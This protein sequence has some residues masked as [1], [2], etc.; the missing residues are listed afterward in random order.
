MQALQRLY[1]GLHLRIN[2]AKSAVAPAH[3]RKFLG[4]GFWISR[5]REVMLRVA[6]T[7]MDAMKDRVREITTRS[8]GRSMKAVVNEL[9]T[10]LTG[11]KQYFQLAQTPRIFA[12]LDGWIRRRLRALQLK[13]WKRGRTAYRELRKLGVSDFWARMVA[14]SIP[15]LYWTAHTHAQVALPTSHFDRLGVPRLAP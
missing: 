4:Y 15:R 1:A 10:Y 12:H 9:R 5:K 8:G 13:Q 11:W 14:S 6:P 2:E 7:A 3:I